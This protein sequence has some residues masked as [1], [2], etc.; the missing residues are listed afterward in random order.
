MNFSFF[1]KSIAYII[2]EFLYGYKLE[3]EKL[4]KIKYLYIEPSYYY[5]RIYKNKIL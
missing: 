3:K 5:F 2:L 1:I 4:Y